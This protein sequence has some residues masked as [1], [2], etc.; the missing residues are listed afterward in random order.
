MLSFVSLVFADVFLLC[1]LYGDWT[2]SFGVCCMQMLL[3]TEEKGCDFLDKRLADTTKG[4][5]ARRMKARLYWRQ[6]RI[7]RSKRGRPKGSVGGGRR[8][9]VMTPITEENGIVTRSRTPTHLEE[10]DDELNG[11]NTLC[12]F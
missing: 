11:H 7:R 6:I 12:S 8:V 9:D 2:I 3:R 5:I 1:V 4:E 10:T